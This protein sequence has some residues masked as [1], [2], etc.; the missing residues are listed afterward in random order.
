MCNKSENLLWQIRAVCGIQMLSALSICAHLSGNTR[1]VNV[2]RYGQRDFS[3]FSFF[4]CILLSNILGKFGR[5]CTI[6]WE[7]ALPHLGQLGLLY[8]YIHQHWNGFVV[9]KFI[10]C[11]VLLGIGVYQ[12]QWWH[13]SMEA[14]TIN[15]IDLV[16][17]NS[18]KYKNN[19]SQCVWYNFLTTW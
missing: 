16:A 13:N 6:Y 17:F 3:F 14:I 19:G 10:V 4:S 7:L 15:D 2:L 11:I 1:R 8:V 18:L 5:F 12:Q 9:I